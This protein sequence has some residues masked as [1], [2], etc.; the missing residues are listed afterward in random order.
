[1]HEVE[2]KAALGDKQGFIAKLAERGC[3]LLAE[4][5]QDDTVYVRETGSLEVFLGNHE[6][7][8]L[9]VENNSRTLFAFKKHRTRSN[10]PNSAPLELE[11]AVDSREKME[12]VLLLMGYQEAMRIKKRRRKGAY[13]NWEVCI[14]EV[15]GLGTFVELE[16]L[17][18]DRTEAA[19][20]QERM[21]AFL[22]ELGI[23]VGSELRDR[24][25]MLLLNKK[26][27][28]A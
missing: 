13:E 23:D 25:D 14:D 5:A 12:Q 15:E 27:S 19:G 24:Y 28:A 6:F 10:D 21:K 3:E 1:M 11:L 18:G 20:I 9:R 7:L 16:E 2:V 22:A 4:I 26:Y 17:V 8:R